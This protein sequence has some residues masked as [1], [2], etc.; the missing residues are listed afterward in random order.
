[1]AS[2][3]HPAHPTSNAPHA[4]SG[5]HASTAHATASAAAAPAPA[6]PHAATA[7]HAAP[8]AKPE[9]HEQSANSDSLIPSL[10]PSVPGLDSAVIPAPLTGVRSTWGASKD[11]VPPAN[12]Q[13]KADAISDPDGVLE[14]N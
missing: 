11:P 5:G 8:A 14:G 7:P 6:S 13:P 3:G 4:S 1:M 12:A 10:S 2:H 9:A